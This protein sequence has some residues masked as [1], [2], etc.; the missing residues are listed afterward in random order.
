[1]QLPEGWMRVEAGEGW[2]VAPR[3]EIDALRGCGADRP[4]EIV[5]AREAGA[6]TGRGATARVEREGGGDYF[7]KHYRR[8]GL[9]ARINPERYF[10]LDRFMRELEVGRR[11]RAAGLPLGEVFAQVFQPARPGWRVWGV[12]RLIAGGTDLARLLERAGEDDAELLWSAALA[13][14]CLMGEKGLEHPDLNLGNLVAI[15]SEERGWLV[16]VV[17]LD[18]ARFGGQPLARDT[19][20]AML[21]RLERSWVKIFG[22]EGVLPARR[23]AEIAR[24][25]LALGSAGVL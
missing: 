8:G 23:R 11:A 12:A 5:R 22:Q 17:D 10:G 6:G 1:M 13:T 7:I 18:R 2:L 21:A 19:R 24:K 20:H 14:L 4:W 9:L 25:A 16:H 15:R 3:K